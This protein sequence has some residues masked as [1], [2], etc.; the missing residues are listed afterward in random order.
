MPNN[1]TLQN[2]DASAEKQ[3]SHF[4]VDHLQ[5]D[6]GGR[7]ARG[8]AVALVSNGLRFIVTIA[9]PSV[10]ARL[11]SPEDYGL[12][13]MVAIFINFV[14]MFR[15]MGLSVATIQR[16][17][18]NY[19][20]VSTLFWFNFALSV[21]VMLFISALAPAVSWFYGEPRLIRITISSAFGIVLG[22][23]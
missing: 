21:A 7:A 22:G 17:K 4:S 6:L 18:I 11:L 15:D 10:M 3:D 8:G 20:Q 13:G 5:A 23:L 16:D 2:P 14:S 19:D 1:S 12:I 9:A